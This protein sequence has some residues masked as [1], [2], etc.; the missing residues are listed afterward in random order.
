MSAMTEAKAADVAPFDDK[1]PTADVTYT[2]KTTVENKTES[3]SISLNEDVQEFITELSLRSAR[4]R[5]LSQF[6]NDALIYYL[7]SDDETVGVET[8]TE[9]AEWTSEDQIG[10]AITKT[11]WE[12]IDLLVNH[13]HTQWYSKQQFYICALFSYINHGFPVVDRR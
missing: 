12:E 2:F 5:S 8:I 7:N 11:L 4:W 1:T 9:E 10:A 6:I 3:V 13:G